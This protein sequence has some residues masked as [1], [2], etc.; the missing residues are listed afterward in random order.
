M[1]IHKIAKKSKRMIDKNFTRDL[2][3]NILPVDIDSSDYIF[4]FNQVESEFYLK[5][6]SLVSHELSKQGIPSCFLYQDD[7]L[8]PYNPKFKINGFEISNAF[9][10]KDRGAVKP[11]YS[12]NFVYDWIID[13]ENERIETH[14]VNFFPVIQATLRK[15]QKRYNV[16][17]YNE[18]NSPVYSDLLN[19]CDLLLEYFLLFKDYTHKNNKK[20]RL[21]GF[22]TSFIPNGVFKIL[23]DHLSEDRDVEFIELRRGYIYY[24]GNHHIRDSYITLANLTKTKKPYA[25]TVSRQEMAAFEASSIDFD[26]LSKPIS[27]ALNKGVYSK[28]PESQVRVIKLKEEYKSQGKKIF[29]LFSHLFYDTPVDDNS[30]AFNGM[31]EWISETIKYFSRERDLL[32]IKPHPVEFMK[33]EPKKTPN[34]TLASF[35]SDTKLPENIIMLD[36]HQ[37]TVKDLSPYITCGLIWRSSVAMELTFLE[38]PNII[39]GTPIYNSLDLN[40]V[41]DKA[42]YFQMIAQ[43]QEFKVAEKQ[44]LDVAKYLYLLE[45][46]HMLVETITYNQKYR[47]F[48]W[49]RDA[50]AAYLQNGDGRITSVVEKML[51]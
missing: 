46:N 20:I 26:K 28:P 47:K 7:Q 30:S 5:L 3:K 18:D 44:K 22:E 31:C 50:L 32:L 24:F 6:Y 45:N 39:A 27:N 38:I 48:F 14:E 17:F 10:I 1:L 51:N 49:N 21:V 35:L 41:K 12:R 13:I 9:R 43:V 29:C 2:L 40:Y 4:I 33:G 34:E 23:C 8:S 11:A 16:Y 15:I 25:F 37:F 19:S 42:H 36:P